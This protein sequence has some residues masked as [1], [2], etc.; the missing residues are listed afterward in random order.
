VIKSAIVRF[1]A[2]ISKVLNSKS[3]QPL[4]LGVAATGAALGSIILGAVLRQIAKATELESIAET[5]NAI[6][7]APCTLAAIWIAWNLA[8]NFKIRLLGPILIAAILSVCCVARFLIASYPSLIYRQSIEGYCSQQ[9]FWLTMQG[10]HWGVFLLVA[11]TTAK[12]VQWTSGI[13][14][15]NTGAVNRLP[16]SLSISRLVLLVTLSAAIAFSYQRWFLCF[17][18]GIVRGANGP[19][20]YEFFP[21]GARPWAAGLVGGLLLPIH[22][23]VITAILEVTRPTTAFVYSRLMRLLIRAIFLALWCVLASALHLASSK[24]Y[25]S[26]LILVNA[27][28]S[29]KYLEYSI[30]IPYFMPSFYSVENPSITFGFWKLTTN[31]YLFKSAL[32]ICLVLTCTW[33]LGKLGYRIG[34]NR[35]SQASEP[36]KSAE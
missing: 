7:F 3:I 18:Q 21:L 28:A 33:W 17:S 12:I 5:S 24:L 32:Q 1:S 26:N 34:F 4:N 16:N 35:K 13:G 36:I 19:A 25:F 14:I 27:S 30:G 29:S 23:L 9:A 2:I 6:L 20:W 15:R 22:W 31:Y 8:P 10:F 11:I